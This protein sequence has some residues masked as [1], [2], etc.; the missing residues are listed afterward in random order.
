MRIIPS[1]EL[2][3][4][5]K[6]LFLETAFRLPARVEED[7]AGALTREESPQGRSVLGILSENMREARESR[8][9]LCQDTGLPQI[10]LECGHEVAWSGEP[11]AEACERG[12]RDA[13]RE[14]GLRASGCLPLT[15]ENLGYSL[16][17][18]VEYLPVAGDRATVYTLAKGGG[19]DNKSVLVNLPPTAGRD[20][21][22]RAA[23]G[24]AMAAGPDAC[25]P[26]YMGVC[27]G[28]TFESAPR[29]AR[30][31]LWGILWGPPPTDEE[32]ALAR[33]IALAL[34][35][36]GLGPLC[37]GGRVTVLG[38]RAAVRPTHIASLPV[39]VNLCCHSFRP[40]RAVL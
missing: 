19:C 40:G 32:A 22:V 11:P 28:G 5:V 30:K 21:A 34:N 1:E 27:V 16:P 10:L 38:V 24:A 15:R 8:I 23:S 12:A 20:E 26:F 4:A 35:A 14:G 2:Y 7:L 25:P 33:D 36:S 18:S 31:A 39:A 29:Y 37:V 17:V 3:L 13:Y 9:P 6:S